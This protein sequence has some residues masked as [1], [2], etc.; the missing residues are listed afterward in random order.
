MVNWTFIYNTVKPDKKTFE[1]LGYTRYPAT[2]E[3]EQSKPPIGGINVGVSEFTDDR[4]LAIEAAECITS[5]ENQVTY[6][7]ETANMPSREA[8]Y[9]DP[10]LRKQFPER[11]LT[12]WLNSIDNAGP[13]PP[14]PYWGTIVGAVL[15]NWHPA[16]SVSEDTPKKSATFIENVLNG[17]AL[18]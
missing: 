11:L 9:D 16:A 2:V 7:V 18:L 14:S 1:D 15:N 4:D 12:L 8:A 3:G 17:D 10:A 13:R 6:A 5:L